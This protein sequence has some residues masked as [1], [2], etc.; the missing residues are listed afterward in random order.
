MLLV[1]TRRPTLGDNRRIHHIISGLM[2]TNLSKKLN[3]LTGNPTGRMTG[4][5]GKS[6]DSGPEGPALVHPGFRLVELTA[7]GEEVIWVITFTRSVQVSAPPL[8]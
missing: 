2:A 6:K 5:E 7:R 8:A 1:V 3:V 4:G